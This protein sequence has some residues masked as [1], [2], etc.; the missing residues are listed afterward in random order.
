MI[1]LMKLDFSEV[2]NAVCDFRA[3]TGIDP[4]RIEVDK[5]ALA[6]ASTNLYQWQIEQ[7]LETVPITK[8][9]ALYGI[10]CD[11]VA[12]LGSPFILY[13]G[14]ETQQNAPLRT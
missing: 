6:L 11:A 8:G 2:L 14:E 5:A 10:H 4:S 7:Q 9:M 3:T 12:D 13:G 1:R